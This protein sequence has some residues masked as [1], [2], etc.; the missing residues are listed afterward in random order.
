MKRNAFFQLV[1]KPDGVYIKSYP[2]VDG[3]APLKTDDILFYLEKKKIQDVLINDISKFVS[4]TIEQK[5]QKNLELKISSSPILP[6]KE[7]PVVTI[8]PE[9]RLAKVR[10][11]APSNQ[12]SR[13]SLA[14]LKNLIEQQ[15]VHHGLIEANLQ[16]MLKARLYCTDVLIAKATLPVQGKSANITYHFNVNKTCKPKTAEDGSV[17]FHNLDMIESVGEGQLLATLEPADFGT[18]GIDVTGVPM[19]PKKVD[20]LT[21]K[22]G[23]NIHLSEDKLEMYSDISGNVTLV[24]DTVFVSNQFE[25]PADVGPATGDIDYD[26]SVL[27]RGN[28]LTGYTIKA[29]GDITVNGAVE[30]ATLIAGGKIV[31]KRGIQGMK[32]GNMQAQGDIIAHFIESSE[33]VSGGKIMSEAIMHSQVVAQ[34]TITVQGKRG[35][36]AGGSVQTRNRIEMKTAGSTMGTTTA[37]EVGVDPK[38]VEKYRLIEKEI[39]QL[40][41]ERE[42]LVR[43]LGILKKRM[44]A[45]HG[46]MDP[47]K[48]ELLKKSSARVQEIDGLLEQKNQEYEAMEEEIGN[49]SDGRI[50]VQ[51]TAYPGVK[52]TIS[53]VT[54]FIHTETQHCAFVRDGADIRVRP[55]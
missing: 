47:E 24:N 35:M 7:Y 5:E 16:A 19:K 39:E 22:H 25:V 1:N 37:L 18:P 40:N 29:T 30:G 15:G 3:G 43:N 49:Q 13:L 42:G 12:G 51:D 50:I 8:D 52:L 44:D 2:A 36:I 41:G 26:G 21:L 46:K 53:N 10:L 6:E 55:I 23:K 20:N 38:L 48:M 28:V 34:D 11:Y 4:D 33:V 32:R 14:E 54:N 27:V 45:N 9:R 31:L 17:D